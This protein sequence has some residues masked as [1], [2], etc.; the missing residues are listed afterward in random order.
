MKTLTRSTAALSLAFASLA[1]AQSLDYPKTPTIDHVDTYHG[2]D[3][4][5]PYRWLEEDVRE[6]DRVERWVDS[7]N[8]VTFGYLENIPERNAIKDRLTEL[9]NYEKFGTPF[10]AG[11]RYYFYKNDGLQNQYVLYTMDSFDGEP[12]VL[13]DPN[14]WSED[15]TVAMAGTAFSDDGKHVAYGIQESGSDWRTWKFRNI[16][17]GEDLADTLEWIKFSGVTWA[18]N[19]RGVFYGRYDAPQEG[20]AFTSLN[21]GM[22]VFY[23]ELGTD[24]S[25]DVLVF[26]SPE[27]PEW[28]YGISV[29]EDGR[30]MVLTVWKGTDNKYRILVK[31]LNQ[32]YGMPYDLIDEF[33]HDYSLVGN[34]GTTLFFFTD[35]DA[36]NGRLIAIDLDNPAE[37]HWDEIIPEADAPL[38][39]VGL[40]ANMFVA[41][42]MRDVKTEV[43]LFTMDGTHVRDV[44]LPGPGT[45]GGFGGKQTDT[46]TFYSFQ[47]ITTPPSI[48]RYN[49]ITGQSELLMQA[50]VDF[51][52]DDYV[53]NQV[54]YSSKDGT[55]VPMFVAHRKDLQ[56]NGNNPTLLYGYGGFN[57]SLRPG[58]SVGR[59]AWMEMGGVFAMPNLRG[60]GE[61]GEAWHVQG[62]RH[63]KQNVFDDF[64]AA[65]EYLIEAGYTKPS[66]LGIQGR[67]NG[68]LLVGAVMTQRPEL[69]GAALPGVGVMD[70][71][72][73]HKFT[74]GRFWVDEYGSADEDPAMFETLLAYSP[75]HNIEEG[76]SYPPTLVVT[77][78]TDD[79][80][81][82]GHSF[83]FMAALQEAQAGSNPVLIRIETK[84]GHGAG[85]PTSKQI[86]EIAD[87][88]SFLVKNLGLELP[89]RR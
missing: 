81:V 28:G 82:P 76:V 61:Y 75:L 31:D 74:A 56:L 85:K 9:W 10:K 88:W 36:P 41:S 89:N 46:E 67:S 83:K 72:R 15:G 60:G 32:P 7:Q 25:E 20:E 8:E 87:E 30:Y 63:D 3:V 24:Q 43:R 26:H 21:L 6:S 1:T 48:Y 5:D 50:Q 58:F 49:M 38:A 39:G 2:V 23:H 47:S 33:K 19:N 70:M 52:P 22:K 34:D 55:R 68:G 80:V 4:Q 71:L 84:A 18:P 27:K 35:D 44:E 37:E 66:K 65:A 77:A 17:T 14:T 57:I 62:K 53:T 13:F 45:A 29:T 40:T 59:L 54:F 11:G 64:I 79:R 86:E 78:D 42:Y 12:R 51:D 73:F 69:F 16:E